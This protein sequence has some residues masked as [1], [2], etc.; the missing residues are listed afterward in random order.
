MKVAI[1]GAFD[2]HNY[3]DILFPLILTKF[4]ENNIGNVD[5]DYYSLTES[6]LEYCGGYKTNTLSM[7]FNSEC[8]Y[9][10]VIIAG[11]DV[12]SSY[13]YVMDTHVTTSNYYVYFLKLIKK[14][15]GLKVVNNLVSNKY[16]CS[17]QLPYVF[18]KSHFN[19][20]PKNLVFNCVG[21]S[22]VSQLDDYY[23]HYMTNS[24]KFSDSVSYR[25]EKLHQKLN[26]DGVI[27]DLI[28][29]SALIMSDYFEFKKTEEEYIVFQAG[30]HYAIKDLDFICEQL[31]LLSQHIN[32]KLVPIGKAT[33]HEDHILLG[34]IHEKIGCESIEL[35]KNDHVLEIMK[36][37]SGSKCYIG[38][39]LHG[40]ITSMSY[41][42]PVCAIYTSEVKKLKEYNKTWNKY[43][44]NIPTSDFYDEALNLISSGT[45]SSELIAEQKKRI[46]HF[47]ENSIL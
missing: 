29:D 1:V 36:V 2:R 30:L 32:I 44:K 33:G 3:G 27:G 19:N 47:L 4:I 35:F 14:T 37:I 15:L 22:G 7:L 16:N 18:D 25:D 39:S 46:N 26:S 6:D 5:I 43:A 8:I 17:S 12:L 41:S 42:V 28:P 10:H 38:T 34:K 21:G 20:T 9:D 40:A 45:I 31:K 23:Y 24:L 13:W 11:G